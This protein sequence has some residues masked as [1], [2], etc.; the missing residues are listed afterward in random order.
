[1]RQRI[2]LSLVALLIAVVAF[3]LGF[4]LK[5]PDLP[6]QTPRDAQRTELPQPITQNTSILSSEQPV[7]PASGHKYHVLDLLRIRPFPDQGKLVSLDVVSQPSPLYGDA[8]NYMTL[9]R[10]VPDIANVRGVHYKQMLGPHLCIY[11]VIESLPNEDN[12]DE[13]TTVGQ[14]TVELNQGVSPPGTLN[15]W[16]VEPDGV[17]EVTTFDGTVRNLPRVRFWQYEDGPFIRSSNP[18]GNR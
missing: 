7:P 11:D 18:R 13:P 3:S 2:L 10:N 9:P 4:E 16:D 15:N 1:M 17:T 5:R 8:V 6:N 14:I 12:V